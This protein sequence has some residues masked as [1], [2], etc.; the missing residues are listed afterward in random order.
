MIRPSRKVLAYALAIAVPTM[1]LLVLGLLSVR[2]QQQAIAQLEAANRRL[3]AEQAASLVATRLA[4]A[5]SRC[6]RDDAWGTAVVGDGVRP[7]AMRAIAQRHPVARQLL[8]VRDGDVLYPR[9]TTPLELDGAG[10][11]AECGASLA[12]AES[13]EF[14]GHTDDAVRLYTSC[15]QASARPATRARVLARIARAERAGGNA[16]RAVDVYAQLAAQHADDEDGFARPFGLIVALELHDLQ[17]GRHATFLRQARADLLSGRWNVSDEQARY[18]LDELSVRIGAAPPAGSPAPFLEALGIARTMQTALPL[19]AAAA[20]G[21]VGSDDVRLNGRR[22]RIFHAPIARDARRTQALVVPDARWVE[23]VA[24]PAALRDAGAPGDARLLVDDGAPAPGGVVVSAEGLASWRVWVAP[25]RQDA[26]ARLPVLLQ[27]LITL[28]VSGVLGLGVLLLVRDVRREQAL[29]QMRSQFVSAASHELRTP[30]AMILLYAQTLLEDV[31]ADRE[32]RRGSYE[33]IAQESERLRHLLDKVLDFSRIDG[34]RRNYRFETCDL[35]HSVTAAVRLIEPQLTR[36][37]FTLTQDLASVPGVR[38][39]TEA[40]TGAVLNLLENAAKYSGEARAITLRLWADDGCARIA[41][42][43]YGIGIPA[44]DLPR[45]GE[46]F[47]RTARSS[48]IGGYGLGLYLVSHAMTA[49]GG[50]MAVASAPGEGST[51]TLVMPRDGAPQTKEND[52]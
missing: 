50:R 35:E 40:I 39:D 31:D 37:G 11:L 16:S 44:E 22:T 51:F 42:R 1:A 12:R 47:F 10:A 20:T 7:S 29:T 6:L 2:R 15:L 18:F 4:A 23:R 36:R 8:V 25:A 41:V 38:H 3:Q 21:G 17:P 34:G 9:L 13:A 48:S 14:A 5:A 26:A 45:I 32:E 19:Q 49:H 33:I 27:G 28:L 46:R 24:L 43:D 52:A 30:L